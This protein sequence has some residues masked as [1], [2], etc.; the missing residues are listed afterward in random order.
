[1]L[2]AEYHEDGPEP[3]VVGAPELPE[4]Q[5]VGKVGTIVPPYWAV[6]DVGSTATATA[7][8]VLI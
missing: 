5:G 6:A 1:M 8:S 2:G 4:P 7:K 3:P